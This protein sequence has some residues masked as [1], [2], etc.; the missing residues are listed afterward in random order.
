MSKTSPLITLGLRVGRASSFVFYPG[1]TS[2][3]L[4]MVLEAGLFPLKVSGGGVS[5]DSRL[6][7]L[8]LAVHDEFAFRIYMTFRGDK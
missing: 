1:K 4:G 7:S 3:W 2:E 5:S 8:L 6:Y